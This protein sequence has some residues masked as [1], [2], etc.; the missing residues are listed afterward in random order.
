MIGNNRSSSVTGKYNN[1][2]GGR[3]GSLIGGGSGGHQNASS[4]NIQ[5][6]MEGFGGIVGVSAGGGKNKAPSTVQNQNKKKDD[7]KGNGMSL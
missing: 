3:A 5:P 6:S 2:D 1:M 7:P 4:A